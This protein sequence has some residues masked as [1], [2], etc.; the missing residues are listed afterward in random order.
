MATGQYATISPQLYSSYDQ[1]GV[2]V[3]PNS[4]TLDIPLSNP[5][6]SNSPCPECALHSTILHSMAFNMKSMDY[7]ACQH[8]HASASC[9]SCYSNYQLQRQHSGLT[10]RNHHIHH[11]N[12]NQFHLGTS[13]CKNSPH[14]SST[15]VFNETCFVQNEPRSSPHESYQTHCD[16]NHGGWPLPTLPLSSSFISEENSSQSTN[17]FYPT[18]TSA[19]FISLPSP[20]LAI[21]SIS[22]FLDSHTKSFEIPPLVENP[23]YSFAK[24]SMSDASV[25]EEHQVDLIELGS[26]ST[27]STEYCESQGVD[28]SFTNISRLEIGNGDKNL[29]NRQNKPRLITSKNTKMPPEKKKPKHLSN[30]HNSSEVKKL[31]LERDI[32]QR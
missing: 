2:I 31:F 19:P 26:S 15:T 7:T 9:S 27:T 12:N 16:H 4:N 18:P 1:P 11:H 8:L 13:T 20:T 30:R 32:P 21:P 3:P 23:S 6:L 25:V 5:V 22:P 24:A 10:N 14:Q 29:H 28:E 17:Y